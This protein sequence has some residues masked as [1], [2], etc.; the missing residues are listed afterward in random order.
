MVFFDLDGTLLDS[1]GIW[2]DIDIAFLGRHGISPV[3]EDYTWYVTHHSA[4]DSARYTRERFGLAET[5]EEIQGAWLDMA[6]EAYAGQLALKP[7]VRAFLEQCREHGV[8][9]AVLTSCIPELCRAALAHHGILDWFQGVVYA[10]ETGLEKRDP[11]LYRLAAERW[12]RAPEKCILFED[13]PGYCAAARE[14]GFFVAGVRDPLYTG[15]EEELR[16][17]CRGWVED[18]RRVPESLLKRVLGTCG[19]PAGRG[20]KQ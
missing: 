19:Q 11:A 20:S 13:S 10:Q 6:R 14:A 17:L 5:A 9:M 1:N 7:G 3:P 16:G 18:F 8:P 12:G 15:R 4:P 2:L